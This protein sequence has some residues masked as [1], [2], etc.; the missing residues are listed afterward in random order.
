MKTPNF[1]VKVNRAS[2]MLKLSNEEKKDIEKNLFTKALSAF[3]T[4]TN[5]SLI[6]HLYKEKQYYLDSS[7]KKIAKR[8]RNILQKRN[9]EK[10]LRKQQNKLEFEIEEA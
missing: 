3:R 10:I 7:R 2:T 4:K 5:R 6:L 9:F 8:N 1:T